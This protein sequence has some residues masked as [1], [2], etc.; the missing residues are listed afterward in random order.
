[1]CLVTYQ[2]QFEGPQIYYGCLS[3]LSD[4]MCALQKY[5]HK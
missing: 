5:T 3:A 4:M 1:M 2:R